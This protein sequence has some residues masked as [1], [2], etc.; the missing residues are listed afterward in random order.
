MTT[1]SAAAAGLIH[2]ARCRQAN[3]SDPICGQASP[4]LVSAPCRSG[5]VF[6]TTVVR[7]FVTDASVNLVPESRRAYTPQQPFRVGQFAIFIYPLLC[8]ASVSKQEFIK[9]VA[10]MDINK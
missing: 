7:Y 8:P 6:V 5:P 9:V 3:I 2:L 1:T 4:E 10:K